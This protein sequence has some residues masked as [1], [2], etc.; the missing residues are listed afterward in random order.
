MTKNT[1]VH[2]AVSVCYQAQ[3][4]NVN[5]VMFSSLFVNVLAGQHMLITNKH[6]VQLRL[7]RNVIRGIEF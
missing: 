4:D 5:M 6:N 1:E 2:G 7:M 3:K